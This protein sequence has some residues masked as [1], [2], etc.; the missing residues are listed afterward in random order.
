MKSMLTASYPVGG[1]L[2]KYPVENSVFIVSQN[3]NRVQMI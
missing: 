1:D 3:K 2:S